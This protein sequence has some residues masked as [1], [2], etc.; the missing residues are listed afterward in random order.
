V[1]SVVKQ[2]V[3][4]GTF[5]TVW[6]KVFHSVEKTRKSFP[7]CGKTALGRANRPG[8]P[9]SRLGGDASPYLK[10]NTVL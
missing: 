2:A 7:Y 9:K 6:K 1:F 5:S 3:Q 4:I 10:R 8:E